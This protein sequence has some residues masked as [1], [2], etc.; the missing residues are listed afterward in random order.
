LNQKIAQLIKQNQYKK[1][2]I[3]VMTILNIVRESNGELSSSF[4]I[5][6]NTQAMNEKGNAISQIDVVELLL[7]V[8]LLTSADMSSHQLACKDIP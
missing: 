3:P 8:F 2:I 5:G 7:N 1:A 4:A 6:L